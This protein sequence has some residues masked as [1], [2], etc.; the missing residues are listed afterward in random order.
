[1]AAHPQA[2]VPDAAPAVD[3]GETAQAAQ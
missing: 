2:D 3:G 1:M